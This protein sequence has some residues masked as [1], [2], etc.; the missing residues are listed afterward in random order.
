M[1]APLQIVVASTNPVKVEAARRGFAAVFPQHTLDAQGISVPSGV[2]DQPMSDAETLRGAHNRATAARAQRPEADYWI[3]I[4]GGCQECYQHLQSFAWVVVLNR[5]A[6]HSGAELAAGQLGAAR[7]GAFFLPEEVAQLVR[8]GMELG[9]ADDQ[10]FGRANSKQQEGA[11]G[12]FTRGLI[13]RT[14]YYV[15]AV[16][17]ALIPFVNPDLTFVGKLELLD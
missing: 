17:L 13:D 5:E 10:V 14:A 16:T 7:T 8:G 1:T 12:I 4:E 3:G 9:N 6:E 15:H 2:A 11:V